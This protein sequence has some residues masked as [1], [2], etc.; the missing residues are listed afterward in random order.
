M[1]RRRKGTTG[2]CNLTRDANAKQ[3]DVAF[4]LYFA[5]EEREMMKTIDRDLKKD[6]SER[7][8]MKRRVNRRCGRKERRDEKQY[9]VR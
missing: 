4:V 7:G 6:N 3:D 1:K 9:V 5:C 2:M 8:T